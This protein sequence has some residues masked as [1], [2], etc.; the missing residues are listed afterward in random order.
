MKAYLSIHFFLIFNTQVVKA[1]NYAPKERY[2]VD[3]LDLSLISEYDKDL[4][5]ESMS[6]YRTSNIEKERVEAVMTLTMNASDDK[7]VERYNNW[8]FRY[9]TSKYANSKDK[10]YLTALAVANSNFGYINYNIGNHQVALKYYEKSIKINNKLGHET[11]NAA[12]YNGLGSIY[13]NQGDF[14]KAINYY[15]K[16]LNLD[17]SVNNLRGITN[18]LNNIGYLYSDENDF[19]KALVFFKQ[20]LKVNT[21][22]GFKQ[23][24]A[25]NYNNLAFIYQ[26]KGE[27]D[28][29]LI[30]LNKSIEIDKEYKYD[31]GIAT[32]LNNVGYVHEDKGD[33]DSALYYFSKSYELQK[34]IEN[35]EGM[36]ISLHDMAAVYYKQGIISK[37]IKNAQKSK[38]MAI[39]IGYIE[40]IKVASKLLFDIY[41]KENNPSKALE[42]YELYVLMRDSIKSDNNLKSILKS[43]YKIDYEQKSFQ[44]SVSHI[45]QQKINRAENEKKIAIEKA[46]QEKQ[47]IVIISISIILILIVAFLMFVYRRLRITS[48]Q[49]NIIE[50]QK[51]AVNSQ[52]EIIEHQHKEI[53]DS[54]N[55]AEAIQ[56]SVLPSSNIQ[57]IRADS[58]V[59]F[60]PKDKVS[61][62]FFWLEEKDDLQYF[63]AADCTGHGVP[64]AFI[65]MI[66]TI[67]LNEV[68]NSKNIQRP[69]L[70]LNEL[71]RL[72][73]LTLTNSEG[74]IMKDGMD[75][76]IGVLDKK[77]NVLLFS[78]ANNPVWIVSKDDFKLANNVELYPNISS[79]ELNLFEVKGD[80]MPIGLFDTQNLYQLNTIQMAK[81]DSFY[82]FSDG[83]ADQF[84]G[85][86]GKKY[87]YKPFKELLLGFDSKSGTE[88][89][90][91]LL[92]DHIDWKG[93]LE[94]VDDVCVI[95]VKI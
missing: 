89:K 12:N 27:L 61:G 51:D 77:T 81:G 35:K 84:G 8:L 1:Q 21:E 62:D 57:S 5:E 32:G 26:Y 75:I 80:K 60:I 50:K 17:R 85:P 41:K 55:Y 54:I 6:V 94:Q 47:I 24:L 23:E 63:I 66:G 37:A 19:D 83:Y 13:K 4:I 30:Y 71:R 39:E 48:N 18:S 95:G 92:S 49:K 68:H 22:N 45:E 43:Q 36:L 78:G 74:E 79:G 53:S 11:E 56:K 42:N 7:V 31:Y 91:I 2:L 76:A 88:K 90:E 16:T 52:K 28:S 67:L 58:F 3:S 29:A 33:L 59:L 82:L 10:F 34:Q 9:A 87:K 65:S 14:T 72:V 46:K 38:E 73:I 40:D 15:N 69:D 64:G 70:I 44:D 86:R 20:A 25:S 93:D